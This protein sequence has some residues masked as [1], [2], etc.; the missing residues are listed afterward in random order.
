VWDATIKIE[1]GVSSARPSWIGTLAGYVPLRSEL[2]AVDRHSI[3]WG[4]E[5]FERVIFNAHQAS[6]TGRNASRKLQKA[7]DACKDG[8]NVDS[9]I[10][11]KQ[12]CGR[13]SVRGL[14]RWCNQEF[15]RLRDEDQMEL[16]R[17]ILLKQGKGGF[18]CDEEMRKI[19]ETLSQWVVNACLKWKESKILYHFRHSKTFA[20]V[21]ASADA[22]MADRDRKEPKSRWKKVFSNIK[23]LTGRKRAIL[24]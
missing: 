15:S 7:F 13:E 3:W 2:S 8:A 19:S 11:L 20:I 14:E 17:L 18:E 6:R 21:M 9:V 12:W 23:F 1:I 16:I 10:I 22:L 5:E 4:E 24:L